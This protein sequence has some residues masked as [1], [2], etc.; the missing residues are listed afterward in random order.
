MP[1]KLVFVAANPDGYVLKD[2]KKLRGL[3]FMMT[4][5]GLLRRVLDDCVSQEHKTLG[6][7]KFYCLA[8]PNRVAIESEKYEDTDTYYVHV[9]NDW[10]KQFI[11][12]SAEYRCG[13]NAK[14]YPF[15]YKDTVML[16][17]H[18]DELALVERWIELGYPTYIGVSVGGGSGSGSGSGG[19]SGS[20]DGP[21]TPDH[22]YQ[23]ADIPLVDSVNE[24][25]E[26]CDGTTVFDVI[27]G[28]EISDLDTRNQ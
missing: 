9:K 6:D 24:V 26:P 23:L 2:E 28:I 4:A 12:Y 3:E 1:F 7:R 19:G 21:N 16:T 18:I 22:V 17:S 25:A 13:R 27:E 8:I 15:M 11:F 10:L 5:G 20:G 14:N